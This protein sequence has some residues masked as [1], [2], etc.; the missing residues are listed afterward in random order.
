MLDWENLRYFVAVVDA[1]SLSAAARRMKVDHATVSRRLSALE[2]EL[3]VRLLERLPRR[4]NLTPMGAQIHRLAQDMERAAFGIERVASA[5]QAS[6]SGKVTL[7]VPPVLGTNFFADR[8][9]ALRTR[10][11]GIQLSMV[12][13]AQSVSLE[14]READIAVRLF[15][16]SEP[17]NVTRRIGR[18][19]FGLYCAHDYANAARPA[20]WGF[21]AYDAQYA[22]MPHQQWMLAVAAGRP[23]V[24]EVSDI[25]TQQRVARSG[26]GVAGLPLFIG[27]HDPAL[28]PLPFDGETF[29]CDIW[30]VVHGDLSKSPLIRAV[31]EYVSQT[32]EQVFAG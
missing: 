15:R 20:D 2:A 11:P 16:P 21:I 8:L 3:G 18:M 24:C 1:G 31:L 9:A 19:P 7:S 28:K 17:A 13:Q 10:H 4:C 25:S 26:L 14:R 32:V 29:Y 27:E 23:V 12:N 6:M 5:E 30:L 22:D